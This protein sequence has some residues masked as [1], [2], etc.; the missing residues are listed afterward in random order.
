VSESP[1]QAR[2]LSSASAAGLDE[3]G[4][5]PVTSLRSLTTK[6]F[7]F[8]TLYPFTIRVLSSIDNAM[9]SGLAFEVGRT[10]DGL[11]VWRLRIHAADVPGRWIVVDGRFVAVED[12][13]TLRS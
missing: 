1:N 6:T 13:L 7:Q 12:A 11:A 4:F 9:P 3:A 10:A 5:W 2:S 8:S